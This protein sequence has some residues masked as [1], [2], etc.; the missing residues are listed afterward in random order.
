VGWG[1]GQRADFCE[2][3]EW[4]IRP[5]LLDGE[6]QS[7]ADSASALAGLSSFTT[8]GKTGRR[9]AR[10][11]ELRIR[12]RSPA[13]AMREN[14]RREQG[15]PRPGR[16]HLSSREKHRNPRRSKMKEASISVIIPTYNAERYLPDAIDSVLAQTCPAGEIIVV[17]DGSSDGTPRVAERYGSRVRWLPQENQGSGAARN[18]GIEA[19]R[20]ELLAFLDADDLWVR[21]KLT[22]QVEALASSRGPRWCSEWF[23]S[24]SARR[25]RRK[26]STG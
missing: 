9:N 7:R 4:P 13:D 15:L 22:W 11:E 6:S 26:A 18:R 14:A 17:D 20:G 3:N 12:M 5:R 21:D 8:A 25:F 24:S 16:A 19:S 1:A 2:T 23:S 10:V